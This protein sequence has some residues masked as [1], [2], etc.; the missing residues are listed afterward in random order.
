MKILPLSLLLCFSLQAQAQ[1]DPS[2]GASHT[3]KLPESKSAS[4]ITEM[5]SL[6]MAMAEGEMPSR[7]RIEN[8]FNFKFNLKSTHMNEREYWGKAPYPFQRTQPR[9]ISFYETDENRSILLAYQHSEYCVP[10]QELRKNIDGK[11]RARFFDDG[12]LMRRVLYE[13]TINSVERTLE[14]SPNNVKEDEC[15]RFFTVT[16]HPIGGR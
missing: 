11:W 12:H 6:L 13:A 5:I 3:I 2:Q 1:T 14:F 4:A 7:E 8:K 16:Y 10:T 9:N 15:L